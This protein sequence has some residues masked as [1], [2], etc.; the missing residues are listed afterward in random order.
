M[1]HLLIARLKLFYRSD[2]ELQLRRFQ[3]LEYFRSH[4][5]VDEI[6]S[7]GQGVSFLKTC[8]VLPVT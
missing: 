8:A 6:R 2:R 7:Y 5:R 4:R 1:Q 3:G